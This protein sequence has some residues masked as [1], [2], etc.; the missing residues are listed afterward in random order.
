MLLS[1]QTTDKG[2]NKVTP[3][4]WER[5]PTP[6]DLASADVRDVEDIIRTIGFFRTKAANVA[7]TRVAFHRHG[8]P[9]PPRM[10]ATRPRISLYWEAKPSAR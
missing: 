4:L 8:L 1:A 5:Y 10:A 6:A 2:V 3:K 7:A 9:S